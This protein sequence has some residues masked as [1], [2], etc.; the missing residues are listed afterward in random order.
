MVIIYLF[1]EANADVHDFL[2]FIQVPIE[3][4]L[5]YTQQEGLQLFPISIVCISSPTDFYLE[6]QSKFLH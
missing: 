6:T 3:C 2:L 4:H 1:Q 5:Q